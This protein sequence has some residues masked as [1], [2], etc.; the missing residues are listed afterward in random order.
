MTWPANGRLTSR[1]GWRTHPIY[2]DR[3]MHA[4]IDIGAGQGVPIVAADDGV[5]L[6]SYYSSG[7]GNLT[8]IDHGGGLTTSYAHQSAMLVSDGQRVAR[9]QM[10]GRAGSTGNVTGPHLHFEVRIDG[11]PVDPLNYVN[12]P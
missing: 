12:P 4:G 10:I 2:G 8:V 3:R 1:Y 7:Y 11:D 9:G 6:L 5:V